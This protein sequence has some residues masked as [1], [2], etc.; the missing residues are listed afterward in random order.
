MPVFGVGEHDGVHFYVMQFIRGL[1]LDA[2]LKEVGRL[3]QASG[4]RRSPTDPGRTSRLLTEADLAQSLVTGRFAIAEPEDTSSAPPFDSTAEAA[5]DDV[6]IT[7]TDQLGLSSATDSTAQYARSV[8]RLGFQVA[9]ALDYAHQHR[10]LHRDIKPSNLLLDAQG[11]VWVTD[12]GLAKIA[13]DSDLTRTGDIVGTIRYM[14]PERFE[15]RC[16]ARADV[17]ALGLTLYELLA[18]QPAF[19]AEGRPAL[20]AS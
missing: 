19:D 14:A 13:S 17:Y 4:D 7:L 11:T 6:S 10:V 18:R 5:R 2:V 9:D 3:K 20:F 12:F 16:D 1:P 8:A 15:G